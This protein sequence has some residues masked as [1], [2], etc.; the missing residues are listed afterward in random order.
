MVSKK[1]KE[2][3]KRK[4]R[5]RRREDFQHL[6]R[7]GRRFHSGQYSLI[8]AGNGRDY[9]RLGLSIRK[10]VGSAVNRN[11]EKRLCREFFRREITGQVSGFDVLIIIKHRSNS[12]TESYGRLH[13]L[14]KRSLNKVM[15]L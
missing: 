11:Y 12:F 8:V 1:N 7:E 2:E 6:L 4:E 15:S 13:E 5:V 9:M 10:S 3:F 14:F